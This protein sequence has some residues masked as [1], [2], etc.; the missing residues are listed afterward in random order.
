[1]PWGEKNLE[2]LSSPGK[3]S[4][5]RPTWFTS[6]IPVTP[7]RGLITQGQDGAGSIRNSEPGRAVAAEAKL[8]GCGQ[9]SALGF[10]RFDCKGNCVAGTREAKKSEWRAITVGGVG[11]GTFAVFTEDAL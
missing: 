10:F 7:A 6:A 1:M 4:P 9:S 8:F 11:V 5:R 3:G 2:L